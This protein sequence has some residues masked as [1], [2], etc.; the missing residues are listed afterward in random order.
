MNDPQNLEPLPEEIQDAETLEELLSRPT[1]AAVRAMGRIE[2]DL[3]VLGVAGKMGP[4]LA[5]MAQRASEAAGVPRRILGVSRFS[6]P[7]CRAALERTRSRP[8]KATC[9]SGSLSTAFPIFPT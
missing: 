6:Q 7:E 8:F 2:G 4:T 3:L 1:P 5:R 9:S